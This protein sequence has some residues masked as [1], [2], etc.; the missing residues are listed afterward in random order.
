MLCMLNAR[1]VKA[2]LTQCT[3]KTI[4]PPLYTIR[5]CAKRKAGG[6]RPQPVNI[7]QNISDNLLDGE[8]ELHHLTGD[9]GDRGAPA[10]STTTSNS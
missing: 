2:N 7:V 1:H 5:R 3:M 9:A 10:A 8:A 6:R 4:T